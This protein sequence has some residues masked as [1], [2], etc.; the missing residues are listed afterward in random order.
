MNAEV[1]CDTNVWVYA[2][3]SDP[4]E[5]NK[6]RRSLEIIQNKLA[7]VSAQVLQEFYVTVTRKIEKP[8]APQDALKWLEVMEA[9]PLVPIDA[10]IVKVGIKNSVTHRISY[11]DGAIIASAERLGCSILYSEDLNDQQ[12]FDSV[13]VV[14]PYK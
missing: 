1:F 6:K 14:N 2:V 12:Q 3:S 11:W 4:A 10:A 7:G 5:A 9:F 13:R 8:L